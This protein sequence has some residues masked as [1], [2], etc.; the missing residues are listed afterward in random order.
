MKTVLKILLPLLV[1]GTT[2]GAV[3]LLIKNKQEIKPEPVVTVL[4][5]VEVR[6]VKPG[7]HQ[8]IVRSQGEV[9]ARTE[10]DLVSEVS[11][12]V[13]W[14]AAQFAAGGFIREGEALAKIDPRDFQIAVIQAE[15]AVAQGRVLLERELAEAK[16]A[17]QEWEGL[18][19]GKANSLLLREPQLA[20]AEAAL[21]SALANLEK[22]K[23]DLARCEIA[24][25]FNGRIRSKQVDVGQFINRGMPLARAYAVDYVEISLPLSLD[26]LGYVDLA[27][28]RSEKAAEPEA[29][30]SARIGGE[31]QRWKGRLVRTA[32]E[33]D[34]R[35]RMLTGIVRVDD[36]YGL[37]GS[38]NTVPL[39][40][41]LF[42]EAEIKGKVVEEVYRAPRAAMRG[43][44]RLMVVDAEDALRFRQIEI[45]RLQPAEVL[46]GQGLEAG[47]RVCVSLL[48]APVD[49]MKVQV[50]DAVDENQP[51]AGEAARSDRQ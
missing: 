48:D 27:L 39:P 3:A 36:P 24:A 26:E 49:G 30:V 29:V 7:A 51:S 4:P 6:E 18:G 28:G 8:F 14:V 41:G 17:R 31:T 44:D 1:L 35:T 32:G 11:G 21:R 9:A 25:P 5:L 38:T 43:P 13:T 40:V 47:D 10:I 46:I 19:K 34:A 37:N 20:Q 50:R 33:I 15:A 23:L 16:V 45:V 2:A 12:K 22:T 42:V